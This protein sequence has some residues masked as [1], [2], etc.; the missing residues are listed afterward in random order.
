MPPSRAVTWQ[1]NIAGAEGRIDRLSAMAAE[2]VRSQVS[3][4]ATATPAALA[5]NAATTIIPIVFEMAG[6]PV[7]LGLMAALDR[8][9]GNVGGQLPQPIEPRRPERNSE[10]LRGDDVRGLVVVHGGRL[11]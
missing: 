7:S 11:G 6:D 8:P 10:Q 2:L 4:I 9:G 1:S 5:A 3:V